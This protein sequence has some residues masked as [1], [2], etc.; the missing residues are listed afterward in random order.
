MDKAYVLVI[1]DSRDTA[2]SIADMLRLLGYAARVAYGP[3]TAMNAVTQQYPS[4]ILLDIHMPGVDGP[5]V[6]RYL[7]RD[8]RTA[9]VPVIAMSS[10]QQPDSVAQIMA[11][12]ANYFLAKPISM[13]ALE[14]ALQAVGKGSPT[15]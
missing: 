8:P 10:D 6:C 2:D 11:A 7:R 12:G 4:L 15:R 13:E 1:D 9:H 3:R 14:L 5:E